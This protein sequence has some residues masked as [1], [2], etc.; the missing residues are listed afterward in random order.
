MVTVTDIIKKH[1]DLVVINDVGTEIFNAKPVESN[2]V[3]HIS[4]IQDGGKVGF[5]QF[6]NFNGNCVIVSYELIEKYTIFNHI[7]STLVAKNPRLSFLRVVK[8]FFYDRKKKYI[9]PTVQI[10]EDVKI[11]AGTTIHANVVIYDGVKIGKNCKIKAGT[12]LGGT[13]FGYEENEHEEWEA[14]PHIG[15]LIIGDYVE[16][17]SN[18]TIDRGTMDNTQIHNGVK[19]DNLVQIGHNAILKENV[20]ITALCLVGGSAIIGKNVYIA[21]CAVIRDNIIIGDNAFIGMGA[22]VVKDVK[23]NTTVIGHPAREYYKVK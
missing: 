20:L 9:H 6:N 23:N 4:F 2:N 3:Q 10:G 16:I 22:V 14:V 12:I 19:I 13:G 1:P 15:S 5:N 18:T 21:P 11:G 8:Q 7:F 17:G